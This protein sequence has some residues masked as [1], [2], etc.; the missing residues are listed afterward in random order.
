MTPPFLLPPLTDPF[1]QPVVSSD[2]TA[3]YFVIETDGE[4]HCTCPATV[5]CKHIRAVRSQRLL[6]GERVRQIC[7]THERTTP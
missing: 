4:W 6:T 1:V 3:I 5:T 2:A 7:N